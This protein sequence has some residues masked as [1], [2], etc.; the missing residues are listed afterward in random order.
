MAIEDRDGGEVY[1][2]DRGQKGDGDSRYG[3]AGTVA[4]GD[5]DSG[6]VYSWDRGQKGTGTAAMVKLVRWPSGT[7]TAEKYLAGTVAKRGR[8]QRAW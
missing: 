1:S 2:W 7:G 3:K 8:E 4:I 5:P 6:E